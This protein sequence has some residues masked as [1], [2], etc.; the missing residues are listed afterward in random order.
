ME[1]DNTWNRIRLCVSGFIAILAL[2]CAVRRAW[3]LLCMLA[4]ADFLS[5]KIFRPRQR[6]RSHRKRRP[7][8]KELPQKE[9]P[10]K[11][12]LPAP[13]TEDRAMETLL[14]YHVNHRILASLKAV[15]QN[16]TWEWHEKKPEALALSGGTGR[17][18]IFGIPGYEYVDVRIDP[19]A[20]LAC[21]MI[22]AVPLSAIHLKQ[23]QSENHSPQ[24]TSGSPKDPQAWYDLQGRKVLEPLITDLNSHGH[25]Q[26]TL[27]EDGTACVEEDQRNISKE[28]LDG[29]PKR[30]AWPQLVQTLER[31]GLAA[32]IP[33]EGFLVSW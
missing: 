18:R 22:T 30:S 17:I 14:L 7:S 13:E 33:Q 32:R 5:I 1:H 28:H 6:K 20:N 25:S 26:M 16:V 27:R 15:S 23:G 31:N 29:F 19:Q 24:E 10:P 8:Q 11:A 21:D 4:L 9:I 3:P 2:A 12:A